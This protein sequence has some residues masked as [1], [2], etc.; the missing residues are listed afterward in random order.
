MTRDYG[1][2]EMGFPVL[3]KPNKTYLTTLLTDSEKFFMIIAIG[4]TVFVIFTERNGSRMGL[5][6]FKEK[7]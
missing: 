3:Q 1:V 7:V 4:D 6:I 5:S 2:L